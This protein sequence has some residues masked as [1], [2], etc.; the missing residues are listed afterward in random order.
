MGRSTEKVELMRTLIPGSRT[1]LVLKTYDV[2]EHQLTASMKTLVV[3]TNEWYNMSD[4]DQTKYLRKDST[5]VSNALTMISNQQGSFLNPPKDESL[6]KQ[7]YEM[8]IARNAILAR[9]TSEKMK[10]IVNTANIALTPFL[11]RRVLLHRSSGNARK[12]RKK[13]IWH[14][15]LF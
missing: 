5:M 14:L 11:G 12:T 8:I 1:T 13:S 9:D 10:D 7:L 6:D 2:M 3:D 15:G 4:A